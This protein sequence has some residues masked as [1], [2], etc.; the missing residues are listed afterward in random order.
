MKREY[1]VCVYVCAHEVYITRGRPIPTADMSLVCVCVNTFAKQMGY[2]R[3]GE[4]DEKKY[5]H[6][7]RRRGRERERE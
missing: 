3:R 4:G 1:S 2:S 7:D 6:A 5:I